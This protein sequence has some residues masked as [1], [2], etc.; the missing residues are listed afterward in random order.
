VLSAVD[1]ATDTVTLAT[2]A[3]P[4][5]GYRCARCYAPVQFRAG[6]ERARHFAH[7]AGQADPDCEDY[8]GIAYSGIVRRT[9]TKVE[10]GPGRAAEFADLLFD[11]SPVGPELVVWLPSSTSSGQWDGQIILSAP[12]LSKSFTR[13]HLERGQAVRIRLLDG[14]WS[15][16]TEGLVSDDYRSRLRVGPAALESQINLFDA[17][18][19]PG[20]RIGPATPIRLGDTIWAVTRDSGL[21]KRSPSARI[22]CQ[23]VASVGGWHVLQITLPREES[24]D[25]VAAVSHWVSHPVRFARARV[26]IE[27]PLPVSV[28][29]FGQVALCAGAECVEVRSDQA[30]DLEIV[31]ALG[32]TSVATATASHALHWPS[33]QLGTWLV[34][35]NGTDF[36]PFVIQAR[37]AREPVA[38]AVDLDG[39]QLGGLWQARDTIARGASATAVNLTL[40]WADPTVGR[41]VRV[42]GRRLSDDAETSHA[43]LVLRPGMSLDAGTLGAILLPKITHASLTAANLP[44]RLVSI[45]RWLLSV[46]SQ[47]PV[48]TVRMVGVPN[49]LHSVPLVANLRR[50]RWRPSLAAHVQALGKMLMEL[51]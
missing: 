45:S 24:L 6:L 19:S 23:T 2:D 31:S 46:A 27:R 34:R 28:S 43:E 50:A 38:I 12:G 14:Q 3:Q 16:E 26:W 29:P 21:E 10:P 13:K 30:V 7:A 35:V 42:N 8:F 37:P 48:A 5:R 22:D 39:V 47:T 18:R 36:L 25:F 49:R 44:P 4:G 32:G 41:I 40:T 15:I 33:P 51:A 17:T 1:T 20:R 11:M 9:L